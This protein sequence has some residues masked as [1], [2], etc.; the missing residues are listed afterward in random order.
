MANVIGN[1]VIEAISIRGQDIYV[2]FGVHFR[3][4]GRRELE[5]ITLSTSLTLQSEKLTIQF[6]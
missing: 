1:Q 3:E 5:T 6:P 4:I 2:T